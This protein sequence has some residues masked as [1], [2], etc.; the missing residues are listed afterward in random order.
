MQRDYCYVY[1]KQNA[2]YVEWQE[3]E[4]RGE[5][6]TYKTSLVYVE[7]P[8]LTAIDVTVRRNLVYN[9][10]SLLSRDAKGQVLA[11]IYLPVLT[12]SND[13]HFTLFYEGSNMEQRVKVKFL[14]NI[15]KNANKVS[16][17]NKN[18]FLEFDFNNIIVAF[19]NSYP[20]MCNSIWKNWHHN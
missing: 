4:I 14:F 5:K 8:Y 12:N 7:Q 3:R 17:K 15:F 9:F 6:T 11:G 2:K 16:L 1:S 18:N 10:R 19:T 20:I 13:A